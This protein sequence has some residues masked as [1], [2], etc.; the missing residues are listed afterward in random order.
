MKQYMKISTLQ[1][2]LFILVLV[3]KYKYLV[4]FYVSYMI[5]NWNYICRIN[6]I[7]SLSLHCLDGH[8]NFTLVVMYFDQQT[9]A[10]HAVCWLKSFFWA[11]HFP[12]KLTDQLLGVNQL[13]KVVPK[14]WKTFFSCMLFVIFCALSFSILFFPC[15]TEKDGKLLITL[16]KN[17]FD[18]RTACLALVCWSK[19]TTLNCR[20]KMFTNDF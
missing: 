5:R 17:Y 20:K 9:G 6:N 8:K 13:L 15:V 10:S 16:K 14:H 4:L 1:S 2:T 12:Q 18:Q 3:P 11:P 7:R 19:C